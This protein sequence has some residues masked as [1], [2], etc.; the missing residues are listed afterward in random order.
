MLKFQAPRALDGKA[1]DPESDAQRTRETAAAGTSPTEGPR[2]ALPGVRAWRVDPFCKAHGIG[3]TTFYRIVKDG[4]LKVHKV[5]RVTLIDADE[6]ERWWA[7]CAK[8]QR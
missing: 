4:D 5:G 2:I 8:G 6:A 1:L 3:R 7:S